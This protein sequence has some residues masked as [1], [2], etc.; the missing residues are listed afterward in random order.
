[1]TDTNP[2]TLLD[3]VDQIDAGATGKK[4]S[5]N[6]LVDIIGTD[7]FSSLLLVP[8]LAV[9][10]P[11][12]GIPLFSSAM[13]VMIFLVSLQMVLKRDHVWLPAWLLRRHVNS[14][15]LRA[16]FAKIRPALAWIDAHSH[17]RMAL[18]TR[19]PLRTVVQLLCLVSGLLMPLLEFVPF[20]SSL[21][22]LGVAFLSLGLL[23]RDGAIIALA[24]VPYFGVAWL[25]ITIA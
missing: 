6:R 8:A 11:L 18:F 19:R 13:G 20:S 7:S 2:S 22:G 5:V 25:F 24:M 15:R 23:A 14:D 10:T 12:S 1:M 17:P 16:A 3:L 4:V 21:L 9:A